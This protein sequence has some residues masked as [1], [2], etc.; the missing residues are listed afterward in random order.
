MSLI[1]QEVE[2][3]ISKSLLEIPTYLCEHTFNGI[4]KDGNTP[5]L[6]KCSN[7]TCYDCSNCCKKVCD[8]HI[9]EYDFSKYMKDFAFHKQ[10]CCH[11]CLF[12]GFNYL[13]RCVK[14]KHL[15]KQV[16]ED[17]AQ[18]YELKNKVNIFINRNGTDKF[19]SLIRYEPYKSSSTSNNYGDTFE[20]ATN[21]RT[22]VENHLGFNL[23]KQNYGYFFPDIQSNLIL[24][25]LLPGDKKGKQYDRNLLQ[26]MNVNT[27]VGIKEFK[28]KIVKCRI[29]VI[30][31]DAKCIIDFS[32]E[33]KKVFIKQEIITRPLSPNDDDQSR[34]NKLIN[35][36]D[37]E[38]KKQE[39]IKEKIK[40]EQLRIQKEQKKEKNRKRMEME[41]DRKNNPDYY[42]MLDFLQDEWNYI[43]SNYKVIDF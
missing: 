4:M 29:A 28:C 40:Q 31:I 13:Y 32:N 41:I 27:D 20:K 16:L 38:I 8:F 10:P 37:D 22:Y 34:G 6:V 14:D 25:P 12:F 26:L 5:Y 17:K 21:I 1:N 3:I 39:L 15:K 19:L 36:Q 18:F 2:T 33:Q 23:V 11:N 43:Y 35:K 30:A 42:K 7:S 24:I 9:Y